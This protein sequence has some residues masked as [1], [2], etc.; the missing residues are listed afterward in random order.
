MSFFWSCRGGAAGACLAALASSAWASFPS[1]DPWADRVVEFVPGAGSDPAYADPATTLGSPERFTGENSPFGPFPGAVTPFNPAFGL[2]EIVSIGAGGRLTVAF[3]RPIRNDANNPFGIDLIIFGNAGFIDDS[4]SDPDLA[5][6]AVRAD[7]AMFGRGAL[8]TVQVSADGVAW[9]TVPGRPDGLFP[10]LGY[11][12]LTDPYATTPGLVPT[13]FTKPVDPSLNPA[14]LSFAQLS[15]AYDGSGGGTG[16]D[17]GPSGLPEVSFVRILNTSASGSLEVDA[18][19]AVTPVP[20][21]GVGVGIPIT[22]AALASRR[23]RRRTGSSNVFRRG[24]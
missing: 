12:D 7:A 15:A 20:A 10:T 14:G 18:F 16:I 8:S 6:G 3:D 22:A 13:D 17:I 19:A 5:P 11:A 2:D 24:A 23:R 4:F 9:F 21:P 1:G